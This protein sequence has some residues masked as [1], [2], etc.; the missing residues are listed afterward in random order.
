MAE[1]VTISTPLA[2]SWLAR[3]CRS[4]WN[5]ISGKADSPGA[6]QSDETLLGLS[7]LPSS[8]ENNRASSG[9]MLAGA[10]GEDKP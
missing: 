5:V 1:V 8:W 9:S 7:G 2:I 3:V 4:P 6:P 10:S